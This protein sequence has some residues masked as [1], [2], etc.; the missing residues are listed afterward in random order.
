MK[1][2]KI[3]AGIA[4]IGGYTGGVLYSLLLNHPSVEI[5]WISSEPSHTGKKLKEIF[6][7]LSSEG[8]RKILPLEEALEIPTDAVFTALPHSIPMKYAEKILTNTK[9]LI[10]LSADFRFENPEVYERWYR[11]THSCPNLLKKSAYGLPEV[12]REKIKNADIVGNPGCYPTAGI[13]GIYPLLKEKIV[14]FPVIIDAK[15]GVSGA[16]R[17]PSLATTYCEVNEGVRAYSV[18]SHRHTPEIEEIAKRED[19]DA[20]VI[21]TPH[22]I[23]VSRGIEETIY[24]R[25]K[26]EM[27]EEKLVELFKNY[28]RN[29]PFVRIFESDS[30]PSTKYVCGTN[31]CILWIKSRGR[32]AIIVSCID[33]LVKG[34]SGQA[35]QNFNILFGFPEDTA[36]NLQPLYP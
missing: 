20:E 26:E 13:I 2:S 3:K 32:M 18:F 4:G 17:A 23:P 30:P 35:V 12:F 36:L 16:G 28:Y 25:L 21:F 14:E 10:D 9:K 29:E 5:S 1:Q 11:V 27:S 19:R 31:L 34:A 15:S 33:N 7:H 22:L 6:P 8:E 24:I